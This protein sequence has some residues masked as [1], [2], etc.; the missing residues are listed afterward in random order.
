MLFIDNSSNQTKNI[1][2]KELFQKT[3][4][5]M[6]H[7]EDDSILKMPAGPLVRLFIDEFDYMP[8]R[9]CSVTIYLLQK[10]FKVSPSSGQVFNTPVAFSPTPLPLMQTPLDSLVSSQTAVASF[11]TSAVSLQLLQMPYV[12]S[13]Q[14]P[15]L[16]MGQIPAIRTMSMMSDFPSSACNGTREGTYA[17]VSQGKIVQILNERAGWGRRL[18]NNSAGEK[19]RARKRRRMQQSV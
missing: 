5:K 7:F 16:L 12:V 18:R 3:G 17:C 13:V 9:K 6:L 1:A 19:R 10:L 15:T 11:H 14:K 4:F 2:F 8:M